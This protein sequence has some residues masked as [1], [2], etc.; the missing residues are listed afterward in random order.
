MVIGRVL[1]FFVAASWGLAVL[2]GHGTAWGG[3]QCFDDVTTVGTSVP[4][5]GR[6][7]GR[8]LA[9]GGKLVDF[10]L[11][12]THLSRRLSG[13]DGCAYVRYTPTST[14][15]HALE[16]RAGQDTCAGLLMVVESRDAVVV[17]EVEEVA[18]RGL[19]GGTAGTGG[20]DAL[21]K[22]SKR[23]RIVYL[24]RFLGAELSRRILEGRGFPRSAVLRGRGAHTLERLSDTG[25]TVFAVIGSPSLL[26]E[27]PDGI[28][29]LMSFQE[30]GKGT[31]VGSWDEVIEML[32]AG[33]GGSP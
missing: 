2:L 24:T 22:L 27:A 23:F 16:I 33:D 13:G 3:V 28:P 8:L 10:Y 29:Y 26:A 11:D 32:P 18:L 14:G 1:P 15:I 5:K 20:R 21:E 31:Q 7:K 17:V 6:T 30:T 25:V 4:L 12:G 19:V 9:E